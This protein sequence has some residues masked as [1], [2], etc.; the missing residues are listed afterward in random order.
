MFVFIKL[1]NLIK[2]VNNKLNINPYT[3]NCWLSSQIFIRNTSIATSST[4]KIKV[5]RRHVDIL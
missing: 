3:C 4:E 1:A 5:Q 2:L